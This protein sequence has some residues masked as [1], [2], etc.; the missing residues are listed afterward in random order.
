MTTTLLVAR[1]HGYS[2]PFTT[3][4]GIARRCL[5]VWLACAT[6]NQDPLQYHPCVLL[7]AMH[8]G[9]AFALAQKRPHDSKGK[10]GGKPKKQGTVAP[11]CWCLIQFIVLKSVWGGGS[12][13]SL[14]SDG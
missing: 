1:G 5:G 4:N 10:T 2:N 8:C 9:H 6:T 3:A 13:S 14:R 7:S 11:P 12:E